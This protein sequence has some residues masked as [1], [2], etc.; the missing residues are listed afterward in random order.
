[1]YSYGSYNVRK[2]PSSQPWLIKCTKKQFWWKW[3]AYIFPLSTRKSSI[4]FILTRIV[5][6]SN[7]EILIQNCRLRYIHLLSMYYHP[8]QWSLKKITASTWMCVLD[9][10]ALNTD[11]YFICLFEVNYNLWIFL[12]LSSPWISAKHKFSKLWNTQQFASLILWW[13]FSANNNY[14]SVFVWSK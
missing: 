9:I 8:R 12:L 11:Q 2:K 14:E 7:I 6:K 3:N 5:A 13:K 10:V 4:I 1:V